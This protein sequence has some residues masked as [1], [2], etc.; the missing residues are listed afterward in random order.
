[1]LGTNA[2]PTEAA[3]ARGSPDGDSRPALR[4]DPQ[5]AHGASTR[6]LLDAPTDPAA[7]PARKGLVSASGL[8]HHVATCVASPTDGAQTPGMEMRFDDTVFATGLSAGAGRA[9]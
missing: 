8:A 2:T 3:S 6:P 4:N 9:R 7:D 1:M 5:W